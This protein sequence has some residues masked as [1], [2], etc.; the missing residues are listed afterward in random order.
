[1]VT[2]GPVQ[3][4]PF[5]RIA[6]MLIVG[7]VAGDAC[8]GDTAVWVYAAATLLMI[9][10]CLLLRSKPV[11]QTCAIFV[12]I[13]AVGAWHTA[14][15][16]QRETTC[17]EGY[18]DEWSVVVMS[19]PVVREK[20]VSM[21]VCIAQ[22]P[23]AGRKVR[24]FLQRGTD[25]DNLCADGIVMGDG[26][27]VWAAMRPIR[28]M[29]RRGGAGHF[30]YVRWMHSNGF[31]A[32]MYVPVGQWRPA[33]VSLS[34]LSI[35]QRVKYR[36][37]CWR[38]RLLR[39]LSES[40]MPGDAEH[41]VAAMALGDKTMLDRATRD[42]FSVSGSSHLL[43]LSG[44]H[45]GIIYAVL[46]ALFVRY[47]WR[48]VVGQA[49]VLTVIWLY[50]FL[51]GMPP[52]VVRAG[53][54]ITMY[55]GFML[56]G[57][58]QLAYNALGVGATAMLLVNPWC[59]WDVG[60]Q[61]S[62]M[63]VLGITVV[64]RPVLNV[65]APE[66]RRRHRLLGWVWSVFVI[67]VAAQAG[68]APLVMYYFGR[69]S[70]YFLLANYVTVPL[71]TAL[72]Y[73]ALA[74]LVVSWMPFVPTVVSAILSFVATLLDKTVAVLA[75]LPGASIEGIDISV[76]QLFLIYVFVACVCAMCRY[77]WKVY[78]FASYRLNESAR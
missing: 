44:L 64:Y 2:N 73:L 42:R 14:L 67:S 61:M 26:M 66:W 8:N 33:D 78:C 43:A 7:V 13:A 1:M 35:W 77:L 41:I 29:L 46:L 32:T 49:G 28:P 71:A 52:S 15:F 69:F 53:V 27:T 59:L 60:F 58:G 54:M 23:W 74:F 57:Q 22:G 4:C 51:V 47:P 40:G 24:A 68:V 72:I 45:L 34:G 11:A 36:A 37:L 19:R 18:E 16:V 39:V 30:D 21:D 38:E 50:V 17:P 31:M 75:G 12:A 20:T 65:F 62:Y 25:L 55:A 56:M 76:V 9:V 48:N 10:A 5:L 3:L 6:A 63:A 70:C